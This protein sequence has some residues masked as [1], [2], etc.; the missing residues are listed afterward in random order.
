[1]M[2]KNSKPEKVYCFFV[3]REIMNREVNREV[4]LAGSLLN[5]EVRLFGSLFMNQEVRL[6]GSLPAGSL[7]RQVRPPARY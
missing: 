3:N 5:Q 7:N 1:M 4:R 2:Q 6:S